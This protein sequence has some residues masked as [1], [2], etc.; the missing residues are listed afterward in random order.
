M[1]IDF[2]VGLWDN[3]SGAWRDYQPAVL[4]LRTGHVPAAYPCPGTRRRQRSRIMVFSQKSARSAASSPGRAASR[5]RSAFMRV[6]A[7]TVL[8]VAAVGGMA[9]LS[10]AVPAA[11]VAAPAASAATH[12]ASVHPVPAMERSDPWSR[13]LP[14]PLT[15]AQC[16][17]EIGINC[18][19]PV[20]YRVAYDLNPL[21]SG[22]ATGRPDHRRREDH[23]DRRL[24]RLT[25]H[26]ER[27]PDL[28]RAVRLPQ[29]RPADHQVRHHPTLRPDQCLLW[30]AGPRRP[31]SMWSTRIRSR[32]ARRSSSPRPRSS[33][34]EGDLWLP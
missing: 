15:T 33:E 1:S 20:Q 5:G 12:V 6:T 30:S 18:Y 31:L 13:Q 3:S 8:P 16:Q 26:P 7:R 22:R 19:T 29:P 28:R 25:D 9:A 4:G 10:I 14:A 24:V 27:H 32:P 2:R 23:R 11:T 21:Y 17:A 34:T